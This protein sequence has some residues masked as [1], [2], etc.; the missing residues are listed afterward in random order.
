[1]SS[2]LSFTSSRSAFETRNGMI[3][4]STSVARPSS[5]QRM[6]SVFC[7]E[8]VIRVIRIRSTCM[9][10]MVEPKARVRSP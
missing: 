10:S 1:M 7:A 8:P 2:V 9:S 6:S 3:R 5:I 4:Q